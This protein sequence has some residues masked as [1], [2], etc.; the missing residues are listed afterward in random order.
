MAA[1]PGNPAKTAEAAAEKASGAEAAGASGGMKAW[2]PVLANLVLMPVL[3]WA[4][5][6]F[7]ILPKMHAGGAAAASAEH[8]K[9]EA[10]GHG[11]TAQ[12]KQKVTV[13][14]SKVLVNVAGTMGTRYL[15][16]SL[17]LVGTKT[18]LKELVE[19]ND[20][21]LRDAA[22]SAL[23][24]KTISDLEK[25]GARNLIRTELISVFNN[26]LGDGALTDIYLTE[27]AIQ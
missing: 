2:L 19:K 5:V 1:N 6:N 10:G 3:A 24:V 8:G 23:S 20:A 18:E 7:F 16:A 9:G 27:F 14:L 22:A 26:I 17:T 13:P 4:T 21:E 25:P 11:G 12:A 15:M